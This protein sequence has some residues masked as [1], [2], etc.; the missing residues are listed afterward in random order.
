[1]T[2]KVPVLIPRS[3]YE[4]IEK[5]VRTS[6]G[7]FKDVNEYVEFVLNEVVSQIEDK[8]VYTPEEEERMKDQLRKLGYM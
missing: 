8:P 6:S 2:E 1:M 5:V 7:E 3:L 4:E